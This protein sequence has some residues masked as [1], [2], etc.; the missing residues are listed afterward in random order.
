ML[1]TFQK[2]QTKLLGTY[3]AFQFLVWVCIIVI[4]FETDYPNFLFFH[5]CLLI[6]SSS[7]RGHG[8]RW[9][10]AQVEF[11]ISQVNSS[12]GSPV[13]IS[14]SLRGVFGVP[15]TH[16]LPFYGALQN[17]IY[18]NDKSCAEQ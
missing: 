17:Q 4:I 1:V 13:S 9:A 16:R 6:S 12:R 2:P 5:L 8:V 14:P 10:F 15:D 7:K 11:A 3:S 18:G